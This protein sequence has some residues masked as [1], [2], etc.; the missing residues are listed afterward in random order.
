MSNL[1]VL[2]GILLSTDHHE[3]DM[4]VQSEKI[5]VGWIR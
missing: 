2:G 5:N 4:V 1:S 3:L